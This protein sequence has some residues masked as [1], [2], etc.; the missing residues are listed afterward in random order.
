MHLEKIEIVNFRKFINLNLEFKLG[1]NILIGN[2]A[3][4]KTSILEALKIALGGLFYGINSKFV[5]APSIHKTKDVNYTRDQYG[6]FVRNYP[7]SI[8]VKANVFNENIIWNRQLNTAK[9]STTKKGLKELI[10]LV[11]ENS[12]GTLPI[13]AYYSTSRLY[14]GNKTSSAYKKDERYEAYHDALD[15][16]SSVSRF[17]KWFENEDR[18]SY[19]NKK[20]TLV[21]ELVSQAITNCIPKGKR[22][23]YDSSIT[24]IVVES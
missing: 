9:G 5:S 7:T 8:N 22:I 14:E 10:S 11:R 24:E 6:L 15:A 19:Q 4:G 18:I 3:T 12:A 21:L 13:L 20:N 2:N 17:I 1:I 23:F 16:E